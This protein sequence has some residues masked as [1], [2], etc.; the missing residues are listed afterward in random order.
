MGNK[1]ELNIRL[2][3]SEGWSSYTDPVEAQGWR[4]ADDGWRPVRDLANGAVGLCLSSAVFVEG[5]DG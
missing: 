1:N 3:N 4:L 2:E 5:F